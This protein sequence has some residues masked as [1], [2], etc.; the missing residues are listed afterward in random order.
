MLLQVLAD[1]VLL[2][3]KVQVRFKE[4]LRECSKHTIKSY[5]LSSN[6]QKVKVSKIWTFMLVI[7]TTVETLSMDLARVQ[8]LPNHKL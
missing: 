2:N 3:K 8:A 4:D 7:L 6:K 5:G 1:H